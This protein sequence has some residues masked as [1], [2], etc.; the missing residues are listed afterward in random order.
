MRFTA[1]IFSIFSPTK[2]KN[3]NTI[4][5]QNQDYTSN[6]FSLKMKIVFCHFYD[7]F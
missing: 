4:P 1:V 6:L 5:K 3:I 7:V 2:E